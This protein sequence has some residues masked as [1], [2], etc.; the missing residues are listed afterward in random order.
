ML[1]ELRIEN[2]AIIQNLELHFK[3]GL[4]IVTGETGAGKSILLDAIMALVGG[5]VDATMV[6]SG[7]DRAVLEAI[8]TIPA[9]TQQEVKE[10]LERE[11]L[12]DGEATIVLGREIRSEGRTVARING[13][14]VN[15]GLLKELGSY[16]VDIR[17]SFIA[18][19]TF[20]PEPAGPVR[21][22]RGRTQRVPQ[23]ISKSNPD[24]QRTG[25]ITR[26]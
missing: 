3:G 9:E 6:R 18:R 23:G 22:G 14:S 10:I 19:C 1:S 17:T 26:S 5:R 24:T 4:V 15:V 8:F 20:A 12:D 21:R 16:L 25:L 2:F 11:A 13:R 7:A